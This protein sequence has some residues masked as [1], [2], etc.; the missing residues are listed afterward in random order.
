[1]EKHREVE[2][3]FLTLWIKMTAIKFKVSKVK[4]FL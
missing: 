1:M 2:V 4:V 3:N